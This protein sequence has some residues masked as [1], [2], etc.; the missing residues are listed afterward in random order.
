MILNKEILNIDKIRKCIENYNIFWTKHCLNKINQRNIRILDVKLAINNGK[1]IEYYYEDYP[2]P[3]C[4]IL[5]KD[6]NNNY[7]HT[8]VGINEDTIYMI[9]AYYP[10]DDKWERNMKNRRKE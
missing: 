10:D 6:K 2:Y 1:I 9:T 4:L 5:G 3:S 8:V 7:I